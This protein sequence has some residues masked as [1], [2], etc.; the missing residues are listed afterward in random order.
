LR[1]PY[2]GARPN[3]RALAEDKWLSKL[4]AQTI[5]LPT[6]RGIPYGAATDLANPPSFE[7]PYFI[8]D[9]FGAASEGITADCIQDTWEGAKR[10]AEGFIRRGVHTLV[11][12]YVPGI[13]ITIPV[14]GGRPPLVLGF[15]HPRSDKPGHVLTEDLKLDDPLGYQIY[16]VGKQE[17]EFCSDVHVLWSAVG[18]VDYFRSDYR[19]DPETGRRVFLEF[20]ICCFIGSSGAI[21][22]A[23]AEWG[24]SQSDILGHVL[25]YSLRRQRLGGQHLQ[26]IL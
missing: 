17:A 10:I 9:R 11:E 20:N 14:L 24:L 19:Y 18:P 26:W 5:G 1:I 8:K 16:R 3:I 12:E 21:C 2:L 13:D 23:G 25:E 15:V 7:G 6:A 22:L 4:V